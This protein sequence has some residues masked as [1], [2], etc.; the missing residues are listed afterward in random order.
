MI[1]YLGER[2]VVALKI[3]RGNA[4]KERGEEQ[5]LEYLDYFHMKKGYMLSYCFNQEKKWG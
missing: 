4:Y 1:D 2:F 3:W 5:L